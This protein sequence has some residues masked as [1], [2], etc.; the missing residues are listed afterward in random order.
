MF[1]KILF[2]VCGFAVLL[3]SAAR[4]AAQNQAAQSEMPAPAATDAAKRP[5]RYLEIGVSANAYRG[6]LTKSYEKWSSAV[7]VGLLFNRRE[8]LNGH[9]NLAIGTLTGQNPD[10]VFDG[11]PGT[12]PTPNRF[13]STSFFTLNY[14]LHFNII[15]TDRWIAYVSQGVGIVRFRPKDDLGGALQENLATRPPDET[16]NNVSIVLPSQAGVTYFFGN[17]YGVGMRSGWLNPQTDY[18]DNISRWGNRTRKDNA[19]WVKF[20][21]LVPL[22]R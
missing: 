10:Y 8:R 16:Y 21:F 17:G 5:P 11:Q 4:L 7:Q 19:L 6:D 22:G 9:L 12:V 15:K 20:Q 18:L 2:C 1:Q 3:F 14:D 13:F